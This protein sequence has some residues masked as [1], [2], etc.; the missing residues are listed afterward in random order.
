MA[1]KATELFMSDIL[2]TAVRIRGWGDACPLALFCGS[3]LML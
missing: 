2:E 3:P 1:I